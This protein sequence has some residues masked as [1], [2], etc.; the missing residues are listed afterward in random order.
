[1]LTSDGA[2]ATGVWIKASTRVCSAQ[3]CQTA[4]AGVMQWIR[5]AF[6]AFEREAKGR[7]RHSANSA[8]AGRRG[9]DAQRQSQGRAKGQGL[10]GG[11]ATGGLP[12]RPH[13]PG[14]DSAPRRLPCAGSSPRPCLSSFCLLLHALAMLVRS[15]ALLARASVVVYSETR[16]LFCAFTIDFGTR[17]P[18]GNRSLLDFADNRHR[19][20]GRRLTPERLIAMLQR[21]LGR[22]QRAA[23]TRTRTQAEGNEGSLSRQRAACPPACSCIGC[24][25]KRTC[26]RSEA[27]EQGCCSSRPAVARSPFLGASTSTAESSK[28][29]LVCV[30]H[31]GR[32]SLCPSWPRLTHEPRRQ[33]RPW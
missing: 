31:A 26:G 7:F 15:L 9:R 20:V 10:Q 32:P 3:T 23:Q 22:V 27:Q 21:F 6:A 14:R 5:C 30:A 11:R 29:R 19:V 18:R 24:K 8:Q 13:S 2:V 4:A 17:N 28:Q 25:V 33:V 1:M 12:A 16:A